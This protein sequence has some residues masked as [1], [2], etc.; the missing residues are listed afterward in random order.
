MSRTTISGNCVLLR[1]F[2]EPIN[3][4]RGALCKGLDFDAILLVRRNDMAGGN[5]SA[6]D[7]LC[8]ANH[9]W[10]GIFNHHAVFAVRYRRHAVQADAEVI[11][12]Y[13]VAGP[14]QG[15]DTLVHVSGDDIAATFDYIAVTRARIAD[16]VVRR[17]TNAFEGTGN[18]AKEDVSPVSERVHTGDIRT[19]PVAAEDVVGRKFVAEA[20]TA[21]GIS[22]NQIAL[23]RRNAADDV[24]GRIDEA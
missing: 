16:Q 1:A 5:D 11:V 3:C 23:A 9:V 8:A 7:F 6:G 14:L 21:V 24:V 10:I 20:D 15:V 22:G 2:Q 12:P 17:I 4:K 19:D 13:F 18:A